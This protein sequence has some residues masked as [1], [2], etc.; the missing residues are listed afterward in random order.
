MYSFIRVSRCL[1]VFLAGSALAFGQSVSTIRVEVHASGAPVADAEIVINGTTHKTSTDG[2]VA[3][4][5]AP[6]LV[7][8]TVVK[9]SF[10]PITSSV[11]VASGQT[12]VVSVELQRQP[13]FEEQIGRS[14]FAKP[15]GIY[16]LL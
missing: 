11:T 12:Q 8:F 4:S 16:Y 13:T 6:G 1:A 5:V 9:E 15:T 3:I 7:E 10:A 14:H 2:S